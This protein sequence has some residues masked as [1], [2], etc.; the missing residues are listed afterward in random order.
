MSQENME[1]VRAIHP[2]SGTDLAELYALEGTAER[3]EAVAPLFDPEFEFEAHGGVGERL[4]G[5][6]LQALTEAWRE[7]TQPFEIF[8]T[9]VEGFIDVDDDRVLVLIR[10]HTRPRGTDAE[11]ESLGC[12][13]WTLRDGR[14]ARIDFYPTRSQGL[15]AAGLR[16]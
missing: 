2:P 12:N 13:L 9:E 4:R 16:E 5:R 15:E 1:I 7:W 8:R 10:D 3:I 14:I 6:G 11:I